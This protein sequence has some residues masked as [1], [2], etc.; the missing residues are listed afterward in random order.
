MSGDRV[1]IELPKKVSTIIDKLIENGYDAYAVGGCV[2]D[3]VLEKIPDDWDITTN[4]TP[5][6]VK[7]LFIRTI[8]TGI[9]HGTVTV[10]LDH[11]GFE[12]TTYRIDGEYEDNRHPK[13]VAFTAN[14]IEDLK[15]RDFTVNAMAYNDK[16]GLVDEFG[17]MD[18]LKNKIIRCVGNPIDRFNEDAL[19]ILRA[20]RFSAQLNFNIEENTKLAIKQL[21]PNLKNISAER[22]QVELVKL[23]TSNHP[24]R[25]RQAYELGITKVILPEFDEMMTCEQN[26]PHHLYTVGE[27][28]IKAISAIE[29]DKVLRIAMLFHDIAKPATK[30][31]DSKGIDHFYGHPKVSVDM[32]KQILRRLKFDNDTMNRACLLIQYHDVDIEDNKKAVRRIINKVSSE[33]FLDLLKVKRADILAQSDYKREEKLTAVNSLEKLYQEVVRDNECVSLK[34]LAV[35]GQD[36]IDNGIKPGKEMG[37]ILNALLNEVLDEPKLNNYPYLISRAIKLNQ[38]NKE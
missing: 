35:S 2:R 20:V 3:S 16:K 33:N 31:T 18:D 8:D 13:S 22:I 27:H 19:R 30:T 11:E 21:A 38:T 1:K 32:T 4:A 15:R 23:L 26:N 34:T 28:T 5:N 17:G 7:Q 25:L 14:L 10:M 9:A 6:Q 36:L 37:A 29:N 12:V 24:E